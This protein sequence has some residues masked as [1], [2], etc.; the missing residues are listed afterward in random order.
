MAKAFRRISARRSARQQAC[1]ELSRAID[2]EFLP[3]FALL[4]R[5]PILKIDVEGRGPVYVGRLL[6]EKV[7]HWDSLWRPFAFPMTEAKRKSPQA[8]S[9]PFH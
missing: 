6:I 8:S 9:L 2:S 3:L 7:L 1:L 5:N 4:R